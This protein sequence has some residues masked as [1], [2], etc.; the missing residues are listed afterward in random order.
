MRLSVALPV[1]NVKYYLREC[2]ESI[3][4]QS[5]LPYEIILLDD[6]STD[7]SSTLCDELKSEY[8]SII[9]VIHQDNSGSLLT[10]RR[11]FNEAKGDYV[12]IV[13]ADDMLI[14]KNAYKKISNIIDLYKCDLVIFH[15]TRDLKKKN[16]YKPLPF[17]DLEV[18]S[19]N[20]KSKIY[21]LFI[22]GTSMNALWSKIIKKSIID[23]DERRYDDCKKLING[24]DVFQMLPIITNAT[25]IIVL[26]EVFYYYRITSGS[27]GRHFNPKMYES[28]KI[29]SF[30]LEKFVKKWD[31]Y[32]KFNESLMIKRLSGCTTACN[33]ICYCNNKD[34]G[35]KYLKKIISDDY[36]KRVYRYNS[37]L[38]IKRRIICILL[39]YSMLNTI[40]FITRIIRLLK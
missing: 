32:E 19:E 20:D 8:P 1:Y 38:E 23:N 36:F 39:K 16:V 40:W 10:R 15:C 27:I 5:H 24:T 17:N 18:V 14:D 35:V 29:N 11:C 3:L 7:G 13:D 2:V 28:I 12:H 37:K 34:E 6:G 26:K 33:R 25:K 30:E 21:G 31:M 4:S 22:S 9:R